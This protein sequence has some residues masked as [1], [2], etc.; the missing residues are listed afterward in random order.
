MGARRALNRR[1][2]GGA[3]LVVGL[4]LV[5]VPVGL[6]LTGTGPPA[7]MTAGG[8]PAP[9]PALVAGAGTAAAGAMAAPAGAVAAASEPGGPAAPLRIRLPGLGVDAAVVPVGVDPSGEMTVPE[10]VASV[11]WYRFGPAPGA[12]AGS[13]VL[14]G[15]VDD[16]VQG[17]GAFYRL[18][19][20]QAGQPVLVTLADGTELTFRVRTVERIAKPELPV[21]AIFDR[22]GAPRLTLI[23]CGGEFDRA[24][25]SF[26][27]NVVVRADPA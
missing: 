24:A 3:G 2:A 26:R 4:L 13:S 19:E 22:A 12:A 16:R 5:I 15:H 18:V 11:G 9:A 8:P 25:G 1:R 23:T 14:A 21:Q 10:E 7:G 17:P 6:W 27:D 20:L